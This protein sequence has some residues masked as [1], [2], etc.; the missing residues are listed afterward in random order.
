MTIGSKLLRS[1]RMKFRREEFAQNPYCYHC[2]DRMIL[3]PEP[4]EVEDMATIEHLIPPRLGGS[5][6]PDNFR[7]VHKRCNR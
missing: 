5:D 3:C 6:F 7:L 2:G 1:H 4:D